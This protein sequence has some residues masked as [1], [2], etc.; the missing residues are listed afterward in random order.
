[1]REKNVKVVHSSILE[2]NVTNI[3]WDALFYILQYEY[4]LALDITKLRIFSWTE[5]CNPVSKFDKNIS[6]PPK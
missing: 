1:M 6:I 4:L 5:W 2:Y 3:M